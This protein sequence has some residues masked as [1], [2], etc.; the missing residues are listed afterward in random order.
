MSSAI[1]LYSLLAELR[2]L[3]GLYS[4]HRRYQLTPVLHIPDGLQADQ[5]Q[6]DDYNSDGP[7]EYR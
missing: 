4:Q 7:R 3:T 5:P 6:S 1:S 2:R